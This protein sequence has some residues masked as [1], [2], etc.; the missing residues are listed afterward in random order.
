MGKQTSGSLVGFLIP[1]SLG[2]HGAY[3]N[4][5]WRLPGVPVPGTSAIYARE[6]LQNLFCAVYSHLKSLDNGLTA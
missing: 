1:G 2:E 5:E 3:K 4:L 6:N